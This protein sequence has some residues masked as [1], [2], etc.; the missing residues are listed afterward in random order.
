MKQEQSFYF[1]RIKLKRDKDYYETIPMTFI[2]QKDK[3]LTVSNRANTYV[4]DMMKNYIEHHEPVTV[5]KFLF[6]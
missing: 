5:Y 3:L 4:V 1:Q 6:C 2:V